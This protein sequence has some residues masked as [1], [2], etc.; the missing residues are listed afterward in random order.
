MFGWDMFFT[1]LM[2]SEINKERAYG[3]ALTILEE[4]TDRGFVPN[5][6]CGNLFKSYDHSQPCVGSLIVKQ[7]YDKY[8]EK[9]FIEETFP[10]LYAWNSWYYENRR[11]KD[12]TM[13]WGTDD[14]WPEEL[15]Y[16]K[17]A[18]HNRQGAAYESGLDNSP[19]YDDVPFNKET[20]ML[21]LS[22]VGLMGLFICDCNYL[23]TLAK[24]L[25][26]TEE[27][28]ILETRKQAVERA[29][30][31]LW[32]DDFGM[33]LNKR[34]DTGEYSH[35]IS[36]THFYALFADIDEEQK[37]RIMQHFYD[38][39]EFFG[40]YMLPSV[41]KNDPNCVEQ[42]YWR[43]S[44]WPPMNYLVYA[45]LKKAGES[46]AAKIL[47]EKSKKLFLKEWLQLG[48]IHEN[49]NYVTGMGCGAIHKNSESFFNWGGLLAYIAIKE[50]V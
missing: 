10:K 25:N 36:P 31:T 17:P 11:Q 29:L 33:F 18:K 48:H 49:Y 47:A 44:I 39:N 50:N 26:K 40:E 27:F 23:M 28:L 9:W 38:E 21:D 4:T 1:S 8:Q 22:D 14:V 5:F 42:D 30:Q 43:G 12:G 37:K 45:A 35:C 19:M 7:I 32:D 15:S 6:S 3:N 34:T 13:S 2:F 46:A 20:N 24:E 16:F 41:S